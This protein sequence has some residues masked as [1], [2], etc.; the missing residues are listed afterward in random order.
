VRAFS[1]LSTSRAGPFLT[2]FPGPGRAGLFFRR[3][4]RAGPAREHHCLKALLTNSFTDLSEHG[5]FGKESVI[6][7]VFDL[8]QQQV[9]MQVV[10]VYVEFKA[11]IERN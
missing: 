10:V 1:S 9:V 6:G 8:D 11:E 7:C 5:R 4:S 3:K 2:K